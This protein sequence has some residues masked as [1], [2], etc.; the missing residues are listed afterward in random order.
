[1]IKP[2]QERPLNYALE[3]PV[4]AVMQDEINELRD[5]WNAEPVA[6]IKYGNGITNL[7]TNA[8]IAERD[9]YDTPL[10]TRKQS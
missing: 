3:K 8:G 4:E 9:K 2:W 10:Y 7:T 1:M 5:A 6:W